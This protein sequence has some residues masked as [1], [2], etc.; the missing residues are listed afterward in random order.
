MAVQARHFSHDFPAAVGGSLFLDEYA[1]C[2]PT[3]APAWPRDT[4]VLRDFPRSDLACNYGFVPR[5]RPRL[6]AAEAPAAG[7]FLDD[8]RAVMIPAGIEGLVAV[9]SGV[10]D[11]QSRVVGSGVASTSGRAANG[12]SAARGFLAWMHHQGMEIDALV[13]LEAERMRAG[14]EE[15]R[16]RHARALLAAAGRAASGRLRAAEAEASRALRRNAELE[17]K[18]RQ[19]GAECQAWMG[20]ARSHEAVAVG[21]RATLDQLLQSPRAAEG[22]A[23][24]AQSCCFEAPPAAGD[25]D[26]AA[27]SSKA[28]AAAPSCR[29]C[30]GGEAC[31]LLLPCRHLCLCRACEA[32]VDACPVCAAAKNGSLHVLFS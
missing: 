16:R 4:T 12:A 25:V 18:A 20:V 24:D 3:T 14:L 7:C 9:P 8:Q 11:A 28:V 26:G 17:E 22:D 10:V 2:A 32:A 21:L 6:A 23:E 13:R 5:K 30:G 31:V 1:G 19:M 15:A 27:G 29:S